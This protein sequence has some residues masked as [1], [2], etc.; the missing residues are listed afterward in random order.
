MSYDS[1]LPTD[2][3]KV[4]WL[5]GDTSD[6]AATEYAKDEEIQ[7][8]LSEEQNVYMAAAAVAMSIYRKE[9]IGG[10]QELTVGET[11]IKYDRAVEF[12]ALADDL[13]ARGSAYKEPTAGGISEADEDTYED[14]SDLI[15][16]AFGIG[17]HDNPAESSNEEETSLS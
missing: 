3:D 2:K 15:Q 13:R 7:W 11:R 10:V 4:R 6:A 5:L 14:D 1:S 8:A 9:R 12:R 16:P 17:M